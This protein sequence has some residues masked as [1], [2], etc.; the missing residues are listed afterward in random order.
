MKDFVRKVGYSERTMKTQSV[1][2]LIGSSRTMGLFTCGQPLAPPMGVYPSTQTRV[3][4]AATT[5]GALDTSSRVR[6]LDDRSFILVGEA[7]QCSA[8]KAATYSSARKERFS[9]SAKCDDA[10]W[11]GHLKFRISVMRYCI[12]MNEGRSSE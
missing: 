9:I 1:I 8:A 5:S 7:V 2:V 3:I 4:W 10:M 11:T 12:E 6:G